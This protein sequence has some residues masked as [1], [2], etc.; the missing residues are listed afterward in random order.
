M[1]GAGMQAAAEA[2]LKN[3]QEQEKSGIWMTPQGA[4]P[5]EGVSEAQAR[6]AGQKQQAEKSN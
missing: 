4:V 2:H 1:T 6:A 3:I 5:I